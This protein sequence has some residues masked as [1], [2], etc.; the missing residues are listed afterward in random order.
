MSTFETHIGEVDKDDESAL[1]AKVAATNVA[2][3]AL[4]HACHAVLVGLRT[5][6]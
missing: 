4:S 2:N 5:A 6:L 3:S 1:L